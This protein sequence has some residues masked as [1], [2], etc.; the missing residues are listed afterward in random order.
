MLK[1]S[2]PKKSENCRK[3]K[4]PK[5]KLRFLKSFNLATS[6]L[7]FSNLRMK[8]LRSSKTN[9]QRVLPKRT[10]LLAK[11]SLMQVKGTEAGLSLAKTADGEKE[12]VPETPIHVTTS[13]ADALAVILKVMTAN[14]TISIIVVVLT[15]NIETRRSAAIE[16]GEVLPLKAIEEVMIASIGEMT[17]KMTVKNAEITKNLGIE[18]VG[19]GPTFKKMSAKVKPSGAV[20]FG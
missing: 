3:S 13:E 5:R 16:D 11:K 4:K 10:E 15:E 12:K 19:H 1:K 7:N 8:K 18:G 20:N 17:L 2:S 6:K 14:A 9:D